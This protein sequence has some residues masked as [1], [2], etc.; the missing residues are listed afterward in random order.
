MS[1]VFAF[2]FYGVGP[3]SLFCVFHSTTHYELFSATCIL[4]C[5]V[6]PC[7]EFPAT[8]TVSVDIYWS[9][10]PIFA[11]VATSHL[12]ARTKIHPNPNLNLQRPSN[13][14]RLR[15]KLGAFLSARAKCNPICYCC[16]DSGHFASSCR[17]SLVCFACGRLGHCSSHYHSIT[18]ISS[19]SILPSL[20]SLEEAARFPPI[21]FTSNLINSEFRATHRNSLVLRDVQGV[22]AIFIQ[23]HSSQTFPISGWNWM[24]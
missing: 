15:Y 8:G 16:S 6:L 11:S 17:N 13:A 21:I 18:M 24:V 2:Y 22:R 1:T 9:T 14:E 5:I 20:A 10:Q 12:G 23:S 3:L 19:S 7:C 4:I